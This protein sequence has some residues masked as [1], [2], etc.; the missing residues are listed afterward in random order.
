MFD[1]PKIEHRHL[2]NK[3]QHIRQDMLFFFGQNIKGDFMCTAISLKTDDFYFGRTLDYDFSYREEVTVTPRNF[4][5]KFRHTEKLYSHYAII[6]TAYTVDNFPLYYDA[7]NEKGLC[8]AGLNFVGNAVYNEVEKGK[9][10]VAQFEL[11][12]FILSRCASVKQA[13]ALFAEINITNTPFNDILSPAGLHWIIADEQECITVESVKEGLKIYQN[14]VGV[15]TNHPSFKEQIFSLNNCMH[16]SPR[17]PENFFSNKLKLEHYSRG[18][19]ALGLPGDFSSSSRFIRAS[20]L[21]LN[22]VCGHTEK[23]S[24]GQFFHI[25]SSVAQPKGC[26]I[27][28]EG[29]Y[30]I[31]IYTCCMNVNKGIYYYTSY[32]NRQITAVDMNRE[33]LEGSSLIRYP[34]IKEEKINRQN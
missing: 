30:E 12:P 25:L 9:V 15:L 31:T 19:G 28:E 21:K 13:K 7:V 20:F 33:N 23:E 3:K 26:C 16:I 29:K 24:V 2:K 6:G 22:S 17:Q 5:F 11:I 27:V 8:M 34:F 18:L 10:N 4:P 14:D 1:L 32:E